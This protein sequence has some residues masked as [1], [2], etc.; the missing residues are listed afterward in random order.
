MP[1]GK[2]KNEDLHRCRKHGQYCTRS[3]A[4]CYCLCCEE[5]LMILYIVVFE[6]GFVIGGL[7]GIFSIA[8]A[9]SSEEN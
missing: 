5:L 6:A 7:C 3:Y 9:K 2:E 4:W 8:L 1:P